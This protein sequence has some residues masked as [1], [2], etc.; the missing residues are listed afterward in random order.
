MGARIIFG[1][2]STKNCAF[3]KDLWKFQK[4]LF[5]EF[6]LKQR[7]I[8]RWTYTDWKVT[9][10]HFKTERKNGFRNHIAYEQAILP[11]TEIL[12]KRLFKIVRVF[13]CFS[14]VVLWGG[15][16]GRRKDWRVW[17]LDLGQ[18]EWE[19]PY[20]FQ[21]ARKINWNLPKKSVSSTSEPGSALIGNPIQRDFWGRF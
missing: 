15:K 21:I 11:T 9:N 1:S 5:S 2:K 17:S 14:N 4:L 10:W 16:R 3:L 8:F 19:I 18:I 13:C 7:V 12:Q 6:V 20:K